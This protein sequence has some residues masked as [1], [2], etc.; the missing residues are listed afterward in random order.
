MLISIS[1]A[2]ILTGMVVDRWMIPRVV[3]SLPRHKDWRGLL[4][5]R[6]YLRGL[7]LLLALDT[8]WLVGVWVGE[9][10]PSP[11]WPLALVGIAACLTYWVR[12]PAA[13]NA[14]IRGLQALE[15]AVEDRPE[16]RR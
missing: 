12:P 4:A 5:A 10:Y 16:W 6:R 2:L 7:S 14:R 11:S 9:G 8:L 1:I 13:L 15:L 3:A